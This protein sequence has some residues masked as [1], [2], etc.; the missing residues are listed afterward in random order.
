[1]RDREPKAS[2][3][4]EMKISMTAVSKGFRVPKL[5]PRAIDTSSGE[6]IGIALALSREPNNRL[7]KISP[8]KNPGSSISQESGFASLAPD[9]ILPAVSP[10]SSKKTGSPISASRKEKK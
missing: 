5:N 4:S 6:E 8:N 2:P 7:S 10:Y 3:S 1:M 9:P